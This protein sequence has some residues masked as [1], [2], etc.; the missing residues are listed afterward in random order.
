MTEIQN[1][2]TTQLPKVGSYYVKGTI[3]IMKMLFKCKKHKQYLTKSIRPVL[4]SLSNKDFAEILGGSNQD[5][6]AT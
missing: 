6:D 3:V 4:Y 2:W 5:N 1:L